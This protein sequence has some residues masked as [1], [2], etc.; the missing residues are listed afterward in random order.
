MLRTLNPAADI[1]L[2]EWSQNLVNY[3]WHI[4]VEGRNQA[5]RRKYYRLIRREKLRLIEEHIDID[6]KIINALCA[7]LINFN[8][9]SARQLIICLRTSPKQLNLF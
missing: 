6:L 5:K 2:P 1:P 4:R 3:Y 9:S 8:E 7:Y